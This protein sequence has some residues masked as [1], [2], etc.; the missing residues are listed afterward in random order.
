MGS[1]CSREFVEDEEH[2]TT[3]FVMLSRDAQRQ[4]PGSGAGG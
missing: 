4:P 3:R 1:T 2:N